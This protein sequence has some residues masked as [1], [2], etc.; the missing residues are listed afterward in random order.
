MYNRYIPQPDGSYRRRPADVP[1]SAPPPRPE[2]PRQEPPCQKNPPCSHQRRQ[3][4]PAPP[5]PPRRKPP[6]QPPQDSFLGIGNFLHQL[7]PKDFCM[8]DLM[9]VLLL[10]LMSGSGED[11]QNFALLTLGLYLFL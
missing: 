11:D 1:Q 8:E 9:V 10:L 7:L 5:P 2:P 3:E 4:R 6:Q